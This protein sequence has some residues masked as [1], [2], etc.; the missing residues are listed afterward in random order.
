[1]FW[2]IFFIIKNI[3][4]QILTKS[5]FVV[6]F[7]VVKMNVLQTQT[8]LIPNAMASAL[9]AFGVGQ[10]SVTLTIRLIMQGKVGDILFFT[11]SKHFYIYIFEP[12]Q[13]D[14]NS[15]YSVDVCS[16]H[17][18]HSQFNLCACAPI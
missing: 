10:P 4:T 15:E 9:G 2:N 13:I 12:W 18:L 5:I 7:Q 14:Q 6:Y 11:Y 17:F 8:D 1:M 3:K 16:V